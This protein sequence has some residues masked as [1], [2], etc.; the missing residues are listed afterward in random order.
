MWLAGRKVGTFCPFAAPPQQGVMDFF[1]GWLL[2]GLAS[3]VGSSSFGELPGPFRFCFL[4]AIL[5]PKVPL[6]VFGISVTSPAPELPR[7]DTRSGAVKADTCPQVPL[8]SLA[9]HQTEAPAL[10]WS[11]VEDVCV[12][13]SRPSPGQKCWECLSGFFPS[14]APL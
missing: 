8:F 4:T 9:P 7:N 2:T 5:V 13:E 6:W 10:G 3:C 1:Q 12:T 11:W 14:L